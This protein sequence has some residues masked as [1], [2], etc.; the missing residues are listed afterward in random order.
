MSKRKFVKNTDK[1]ILTR[2]EVNKHNK[3]TVRH[4]HRQTDLDTARRVR[5][6]EQKKPVKNTEKQIMTRQEVNK[7]NRK[8]VRH[9]H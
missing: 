5:A 6:D 2:Q 1:Q 4:K 8:I 7:H 9:K 3:K